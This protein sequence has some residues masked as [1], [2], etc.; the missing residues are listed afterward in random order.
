MPRFRTGRKI[1]LNVY[2]GN[3][4]LVQAHT[5]R[6]AEMIVELMNIGDRVETTGTAEI[7]KAI[8]DPGAVLPRGD[9]YEEPVAAWQARAV[10]AVLLSTET[11]PERPVAASEGP[12]AT[13]QPEDGSGPQACT[14]SGPLFMAP[15]DHRCPNEGTVRVMRNVNPTYAEHA[16]LCPGH[17]DLAVS[18]FGWDHER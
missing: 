1:V 12:A 2:D 16:R 11:P 15:K 17:A 7:A 13:G 9:N 4:P 14:W 5:A 8:W 18:I 10:M 6:E 3:R